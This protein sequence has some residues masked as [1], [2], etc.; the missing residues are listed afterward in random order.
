[1]GVAKRG[2]LKIASDACNSGMRVRGATSASMDAS[3]LPRGC[4]Q[5]CTHAERKKRRQKKLSKL[6]DS[7]ICGV[8]FQETAGRDGRE[9]LYFIS[10]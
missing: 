6:M 1:M 4:V 2:P 8:S 7:L 5:G 10:F 3:V 9:G